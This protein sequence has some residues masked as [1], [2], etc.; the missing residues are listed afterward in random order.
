MEI[1]WLP[2]SLTIILPSR[3]MQTPQGYDICPAPIVLM[4]LPF[5]WN[6]WMH[7]LL[8][9]ATKMLSSKSTKRWQGF[10]NCPAPTIRSRY[11]FL[12]INNNTT[13]VRELPI[14]R[15]IWPEHSKKV[16]LLIKHLNTMTINV[17][18][19]DLVVPLIDSYSVGMCE[20]S[21]SISIR[22]KLEQELAISIKYLNA[23]VGII[24]NS[25]LSSFIIRTISRS[26][27]KEIN[28]SMVEW[29][30]SSVALACS[31]TPLIVVVIILIASDKS[32][33]CFLT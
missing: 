8:W 23:M 4:H 26:L 5:W 1:L 29:I 20:L 30:S 6:T 2:T 12:V 3:S 27:S 21:I 16:A 28:L 33:S 18:H 9:S 7:L 10:L 19:H 31:R 22:P 25:N 13:W 15:T 17:S 11:N 24:S 32:P 14:T